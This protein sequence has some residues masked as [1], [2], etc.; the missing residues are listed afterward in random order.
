MAVPPPWSRVCR[1]RGRHRVVGTAAGGGHSTAP[2][3]GPRPARRRSPASDRAEKAGQ[4]SSGTW[5]LPPCRVGLHIPQPVKTSVWG[6]RWQHNTP[7]LSSSPPGPTQQPSHRVPHRNPRAPLTLTPR[8]PR[9]PSQRALRALCAL[10]SARTHPQRAPR[11]R[12]TPPFAAT[13]PRLQLWPASSS[14]PPTTTTS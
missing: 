6:R 13:R 4:G 7:A 3:P 10:V 1:L 8:S 2:G 14:S 11:A 12:T 9:R 5:K